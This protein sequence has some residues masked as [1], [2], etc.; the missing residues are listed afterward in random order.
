MF[1]IED[2]FHYSED[3]TIS[4]FVPREHPSH[5]G[6]TPAVWAIARMQAPM[7]YFPRDCPRIAFYQTPDSTEGDIQR[8]LGLSRARMV[9]TIENRW[10]PRLL[11][12]RLY[13]YTFS[14]DTFYCLDKL[15]GYYLSHEAVEP[16]DVMPMGDLLAKLSQEDVELRMTPSLLPLRDA[17]LTSS[18]HFSMIRMRNAQIEDV[19]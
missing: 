8:F 3:P 12:T 11:D 9:I 10:Y 13:Q 15:A 19:R 5:P 17:L 1:T 18:L 4:R 16:I 6:L 2:L 7:Y 14:S